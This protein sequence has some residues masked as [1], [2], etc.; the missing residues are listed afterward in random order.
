MRVERRS[1][2][3]PD[4]PPVEQI[5]RS[6]LS[7]SKLRSLNG[8]RLGFVIRTVGQI[9]KLLRKE[10][11]LGKARRGF[12]AKRCT[13]VLRHLTLLHRHAESTS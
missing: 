8:M 7:L 6:P 13:M 4:L 12:R 11:V 2:Q 10:S 3:L 9:S 1:W 5:P